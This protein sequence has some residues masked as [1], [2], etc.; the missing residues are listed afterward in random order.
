LIEAG[1]QLGFQVLTAG[2][3]PHLI[4]HAH[5]DGYVG[6]DFS[7]R[8]AVLEKARELQVDAICSCANDFGAITAAYVAER[9]GLPGHDPFETALTLHHKH[10]FKAFA[11][12]NRITT[13]FAVQCRS[14]ADA[15]RQVEALTF[16]VIVKP[17]DLTGGKGI[18]K[19]E[20]L[21]G[22][23]Q[24]VQSAFAATR[25]DTIVVEQF[26]TGTHHS[27]S[28]YLVRGK[29][30]FFYSD[31]EYALN[32]PYLVSTSGGPATCLEAVKDQ[33]LDEANRI[34][35]LLSLQDGVFHFQFIFSQG[36]AWILEI[37]RRCSGDHYPQ[38]VKLSSGLEWAQW[39]VRAE[40]GMDCSDFPKAEAR[41]SFGRHCVFS[42][43]DGVFESISIDDSIADNI[44]EIFPVY[45]KGMPIHAATKG[46]LVGIAFLRFDTPEEMERKAP[47]MN[48][49]VKCLLRG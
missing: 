11:L 19:V 43:A 48:N 47:A 22:F 36:K 31:N 14:L 29:V 10:R 5:G 38:P 30:A 16:P 21:A 27:F 44:V 39:I 18:T 40:V 7:D 1:K 9:L 20:T 8:D 25:M 17:V 46:R 49:R 33:L 32:T 3:N 26:V 45:H 28:T 41:G 34:A 24:A 12:A 13:P 37:T 4:G 6:V 35:S 23:E 15:R 2:N 42:P